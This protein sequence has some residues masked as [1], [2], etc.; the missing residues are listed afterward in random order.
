MPETFMTYQKIALYSNKKSDGQPLGTSNVTAEL[1]I[2]NE[3]NKY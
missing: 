3:I 2:N 1:L